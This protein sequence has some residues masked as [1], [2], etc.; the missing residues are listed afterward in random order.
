MPLINEMHYGN[1]IFPVYIGTCILHLN[2]AI[3][4]HPRV[5]C[6]IRRVTVKRINLIVTYILAGDYL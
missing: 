2:A 4:E 1:S 3:N 6:S 5:Y